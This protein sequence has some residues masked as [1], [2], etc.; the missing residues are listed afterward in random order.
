MKNRSTNKTRDEININRQKTALFLFLL[1]F[2]LL[3]LL[4]ILV[5]L[6]EIVALFH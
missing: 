2:G 4:Y 6:P 1:A 3:W 5:H